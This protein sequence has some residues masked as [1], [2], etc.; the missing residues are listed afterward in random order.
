MFHPFKFPLFI[1]I[2]ILGV[3]SANA[4]ASCCSSAEKAKTA[5]LTS[6]DNTSQGEQKSCCT[7]NV[8]ETTSGCT[9]SNCRGFKTK[10]GE[11]KIISELRQNLIALKAKME[12]YKPYKFSNQAITVHGI[13]GETDDESLTIVSNHVAV[14]ELEIYSFVNQEIPKTEQANSK[15]I[16]VQQ[17]RHRISTLSDIL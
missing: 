15:A 9:P 7:K 12:N 4:Q 6:S 2:L 13:V 5:C 11:A 16:Q 3:A 8:T 17:L 10:F 1:L 14:I